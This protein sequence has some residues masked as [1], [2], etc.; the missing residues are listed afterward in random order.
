MVLLFYV[1]DCLT[2]SP[3]KG[4]NDEVYAS[5]QAD[6]KIEY[7]RELNTYIGIDMNHL[8]DSSIYL[9]YTYIIQLTINMIPGMD[10]SSA[11]STP[12]FNPP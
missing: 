6:I 2:F 12:T 3:F 10:K 8:S 9:R 4:E 7:Y 11:K 5:I 1:D